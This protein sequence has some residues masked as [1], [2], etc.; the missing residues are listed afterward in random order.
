MWEVNFGLQDKNNGGPKSPAVFNINGLKCN[1]WSAPQVG[2]SQ[3]GSFN[4]ASTVMKGN[5]QGIFIP[6]V[7]TSYPKAINMIALMQEDFVAIYAAVMPTMMSLQEWQAIV[8]HA[9]DNNTFGFGGLGP[10]PTSLQMN[11]SS[12][13]NALALNLSIGILQGALDVDFNNDPTQLTLFILF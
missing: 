13:T 5:E 8:F 7:Q 12:V 9:M 6:T 4:M 3:D 2:M 11:V 1:D 10:N